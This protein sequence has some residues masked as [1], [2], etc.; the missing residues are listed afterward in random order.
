[1]VRRVGVIGRGRHVSSGVRVV[2]ATA[3]RGD[4]F[5]KNK[6]IGGGGVTLTREAKPAV[7]ALRVGYA[8]HRARPV[9]ATATQEAL[10]QLAFRDDYDP[11]VFLFCLNALF[12]SVVINFINFSVDR[13]PNTGDIQI[14]EGGFP[15][16]LRR[17]NKGVIDYFKTPFERVLMTDEL[18]AAIDELKEAR[19]NAS[20][21]RGTPAAEE[22]AMRFMSARKK[23]M[24]AG[25]PEDSPLLSAQSAPEQK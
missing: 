19:K 20:L 13:D 8:V 18:R 21:K 24:A 23:A 16:M 7:G 6:R 10:T 11:R 1:M 2:A 17:A 15:E 22:S 12:L 9:R 4:S 14:P 3:Q 5:Y 25:L